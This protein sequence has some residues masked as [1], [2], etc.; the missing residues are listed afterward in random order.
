MEG[1]VLNI[2]GRG[3]TELKLRINDLQSEVNAIKEM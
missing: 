2:E 1:R 3:S